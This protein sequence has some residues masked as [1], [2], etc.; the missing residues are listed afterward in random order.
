MYRKMIVY[1]RK[2]QDFMCYLDGEY[3]TRK[4]TYIEAEQF[5]N[6]LVYALLTKREELTNADPPR[7][8][9]NP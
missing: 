2:A 7:L 1:D 4:P 3:Q 5:L 8:T 9:T 6:K